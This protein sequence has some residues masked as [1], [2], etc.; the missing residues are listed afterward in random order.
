MAATNLQPKYMFH[1]TNN[2]TVILTIIFTLN[3]L[4]GII[5][6][7][8]LYSEI[9]LLTQGI[10]GNTITLEQLKSYETQEMLIYIVNILLFFVTAIFFLVWIYRTSKNLISLGI[11]NLKHSPGWA[12]GGFFVPFVNIIHPYSVVSE[13]FKASNPAIPANADWRSGKASITARIWWILFLLGSLMNIFLSKFINSIQ[14]PEYM[15]DMCLSLIVVDLLFIAA[16]VFSIFFTRGIN[17]GV[18]KKYSI[19]ISSTK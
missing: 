9:H 18:E 17:A 10:Q 14:K 1:P 3:I 13:L 4:M 12:V 7:F 16:A 19:G 15:A 6:I 8:V 5:S 2:I 11:T